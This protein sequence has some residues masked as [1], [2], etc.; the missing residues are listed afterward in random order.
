MMKGIDK[1][2]SSCDKHR[3]EEVSLTKQVNS[4]IHITP[5]VAASLPNRIELVRPIYHQ[6]SDF[7]FDFDSEGILRHVQTGETFS[8]KMTSTGP[9]LKRQEIIRAI[10]TRL[11][12]QRLFAINMESSQIPIP[13]HPS[14][15]MRVLHST[16]F[17]THKGPIIILLQGGGVAQ[18]G[19]WAPRLLLHPQHGLHSG[20][21]IDLV[22]KA[23]EQGYAVAIINANEH[24][25]SEAEMDVMETFSNS[26]HPTLD[27]TKCIHIDP[28]LKSSSVHMNNHDVSIYLTLP[29]HSKKLILPMIDNNFHQPGSFNSNLDNPIFI[30]PCKS[31][32]EQ[33]TK[34]ESKRLFQ[35]C[36][37]STSSTPASL[38]SSALS[39]LLTG[40]NSS[41]SIVR[42]DPNIQ[43]TP[44]CC[45]NSTYSTIE[46]CLI[47]TPT[48]D[49]I[50]TQAKPV[51]FTNNASSLS[52]SQSQRH[53]FS[54]QLNSATPNSLI[55]VT[56]DSNITSNDMNSVNSSNC[57]PFVNNFTCIPNSGNNSTVKKSPV[58]SRLST[59]SSSLTEPTTVDV[60]STPVDD[61][62]RNFTK[63]CSFNN[64][65]KLSNISLE[66]RIYGM[67][68]QLI[69]HCASNQILV[70]AHQQGANAFIHPFKPMPDVFPGFLS[71]LSTNSRKMPSV[72][73]CTNKM[74]EKADGN[75]Y[76]TNNQ[77]EQVIL[78]TMHNVPEI[79]SDNHYNY[80]NSIVHSNTKMQVDKHMELVDN[81]SNGLK[82]PT[83]NTNTILHH[84]CKKPRLSTDLN[85]NDPYYTQVAG[86]NVPSNN[87]ND[88]NNGICGKSNIRFTRRR[89]LSAG[90]I[91]MTYKNEDITR[92]NI[93]ISERTPECEQSHPHIVTSV[94]AIPGEIEEMRSKVSSGRLWLDRRIY[95]PWRHHV[96]PEASRRAFRLS[97]DSDL[98]DN[99]SKKNT[100]NS[101]INQV[102]NRRLPATSGNDADAILF[103]KCGGIIP[104]SVGIWS[105]KTSSDEFLQLRLARAWQR[106]AERM[107][108]ELKSR[109]KAV[110]FTDSA[111]VLDLPAVGVG[112]GLC[113]LS[114]QN[115]DS[116]ELPSIYKPSIYQNKLPEKVLQFRKWLSQ[117]SVNYVAANLEL[118]SRLNPQ[119]DAQQQQQQQHA[120]P[121]LSSSTNEHDLIPSTV[122]H[123]VFEFFKT[124]L[125]L[126]CPSKE[127]NEFTPCTESPTVI[128]ENST[129]SAPL[130]S[131]H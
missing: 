26:V 121:I 58:N 77:F 30:V 78:P 16:N 47:A 41:S 62:S 131:V 6:I 72:P 88:I 21:Q 71:S 67:W 85:G 32:V 20:S 38:S 43:S 106:K 102:D 126:S 23:H 103:A 95:G 60:S 64:D 51:C 35:P 124:K 89:H 61:K 7:C 24:V 31:S 117:N 105:N 128:M 14:Q 108:R 112:W 113:M 86:A 18:A 22:Q 93:H 79:L 107:W 53:V 65:S 34:L 59:T 109:V 46:T 54:V 101:I 48:T 99:S 96:T 98:L 15:C 39:W 120:I 68:R 13:G 5:Q 10:C 91:L 84:T 29:D 127:D 63:T 82:S 97:D 80:L 45:M 70:W 90:P 87:N 119:V 50:N 49:T 76:S 104:R 1:S 115:D 55:Q 42:T 66:D 33:D 25:P 2:L 8:V 36:S 73:I 130:S 28:N 100:M 94:S 81:F 11:I 122:L 52:S 40:S 114:E 92:K 27:A 111:D 75:C 83:L 37:T 4:D 17:F 129:L 69:P 116:N 118:G 125:N 56:Q 12:R 57:R 19:V 9:S 110:V 44:V 74:H 123:H 3:A